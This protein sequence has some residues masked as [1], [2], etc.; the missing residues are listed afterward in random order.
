[1]QGAVTSIYTT[2]WDVTVPGGRKNILAR[3][4]GSM[5]PGFETMEALER[6]K[7]DSD[8][9]ARSDVKAKPEAAE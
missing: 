6:A 8:Y 3:T 1:L 4:D 2:C 5:A 7:S 9:W